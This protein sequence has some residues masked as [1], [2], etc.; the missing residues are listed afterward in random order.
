MTIQISDNKLIQEV[1]DEF[2]REYPFLKL[3]FYRPQTKSQKVNLRRQAISGSSPIEAI[4]RID[5]TGLLD[6]S[7][8]RSIS[9]VEDD[10]KNI[11][12]LYVEVFRKSGNLWIETTLTHQWSLHRQNL[13]GRQ[14]SQ[15]QLVN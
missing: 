1:Q 9:E 4:R 5:A 14:M 15:N 12:G 7:E 8:N 10:L 3:E 11:F 13:E 6:I 2:Q